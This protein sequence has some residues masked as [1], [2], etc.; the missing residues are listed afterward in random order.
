MKKTLV[1]LGI[2]SAALVLLG[3]LFALT[4]K[5]EK[6]GEP[7]RLIYWNIQNGMWSGQ[8]DNYDEF[9]GWVNSYSPDVCV[10]AE[11]QT[12]YHYGTDTPMPAEERY[13][14]D[15]WDSLAAR[16]GHSYV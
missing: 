5:K 9:V 15:G 2:T 14:I 13:L 11:A 4:T 3:A 7:L 12:I 1:A 8:V 6:S 10:W 16:Y